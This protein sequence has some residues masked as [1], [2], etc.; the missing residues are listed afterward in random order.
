MEIRRFQ[1][2][3]KK[4]K[5]KFRCPICYAVW[6]GN[7]KGGL[8]RLDFADRHKQEHPLVKDFEI[9]ISEFWENP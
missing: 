8:T 2:K 1:R 9:E 6:S 5:P 7:M 4:S 3:K